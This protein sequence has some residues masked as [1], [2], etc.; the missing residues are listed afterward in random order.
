M[1]ALSPIPPAWLA[2]RR[3][4]AVRLDNLG[5]MLLMSPALRAIKES[6]PEAE[7]TVLASPVGAQA[8]R[9]HPD[10]DDVIVYQSPQMDPWQRL[11]QDPERELALIAELRQRRFDAAL[12]FTSFRQSSLPQAYLCYLAGIPLRLAASTDGAGSLLTTRHRHPEQR[13][14]EVERALDL[15]AAVGLTTSRRDLVLEVPQ[16]A[17][18]RAQEWLA[19]ARPAPA[20][21]PLL[22][23]HPGCSMSARTYPWEQYAEVADLAIAQL[24][25][26]VV[27]TGSA[28]ESALLGQIC[29]RMRQNAIPA[30]GALAFDELCALI[31]AA[32]LVITNNTGP[33]HMAAALKTPVVALFALTNPPEQWA[34]WH[35]SHYQLF[36]DVP[37]RLCYSRTCLTDHACLRRIAPEQVIA[38]AAALL[39]QAAGGRRLAVGSRPIPES[40]FG[41]SRQWREAH[42][43]PPE[44]G[45][46]NA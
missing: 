42:D 37:C 2:V 35:V 43:L 17:R 26:R 3:V 32:D 27:L 14:H 23:I 20:D 28:D 8:A 7:L 18:R 33:M 44:Q 24:G 36:H 22:V 40:G 30:A 10:V 29:G 34:P 46:P 41:E 45:V 31:E 25:A 9:L 1:S 13:M 5:D 6:L 21:G 19:A 38:A 15:V 4:L 39:G 12:I 16:A 11:P